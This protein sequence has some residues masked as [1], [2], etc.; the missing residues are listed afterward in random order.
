M[1]AKKADS[2]PP[3]LRRRNA[4]REGERGHAPFRAWLLAAAWGRSH[5]LGWR[6][7]WRVRNSSRTTQLR[8]SLRTLLT[9]AFRR[10]SVVR[11]V[12]R[13]CGSFPLQSG[14]DSFRSETQCC[15]FCFALLLIRSDMKPRRFFPL[16]CLPGSA[17]LPRPASGLRAVRLGGLG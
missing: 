2:P 12:F 8:T 17:G 3:A 13:C 6:D 7:H 14:V 15:A 11:F 9:R 16:K 1:A 5:A 10:F 4:A